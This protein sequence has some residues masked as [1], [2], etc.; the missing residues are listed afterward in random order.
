MRAHDLKLFIFK[1]ILFSICPAYLLGGNFSQFGVESG[2]PQSLIQTLVQDKDGNLWIG[3]M[4]GVSKYNGIEF[5]NYSKQDGL[6]EDRV[7]SCLLDKKGNIWFGHWGGGISK[8]D[9]ITKK[10]TAVQIQNLVV[11]KPITCI[12]ED[13]TGVLW[14]GTEGIGMLKMNPENVSA[15]AIIGQKEGLVSKNIYSIIEEKGGALWLGTDIGITK[16]FPSDN[17]SEKLFNN[18]LPP[19]EVRALLEDHAGNIWIGTRDS[20]LVVFTPK[21]DNKNAGTFHRFTLQLGHQITSLFEDAE[22]N[23]WCGSYNL[24]VAKISPDSQNLSESEFIQYNES[25]G[26]SSNRVFSVMQDREKNIWIGTFLGLNQLTKE[27]VQVF[28]KKEGLKNEQVWALASHDKNYLLLGTE[29]GL[30]K[31]TPGKGSKVFSFETLI[32]NKGKV[33]SIL[34]DKNENFWVAISGK[35]ICITYP[36]GKSK[37]LNIASG[38]ASDNITSLA[39]DKNGNVWMGTTKNG[40]IKV[41]EKNLKTETYGISEGFLSNT[42]QTVFCDSKGRIWF[43]TIGGFLSMFDG[44][45]Y[46][47]FAEKEGVANNFILCI[48][49]DRNNKI[50]CGT[51]D[52]GLY[53]FDEKSNLFKLEG[54]NSNKIIHTLSFDEK[55]NLWIGT[56]TGV[57]QFHF[58]EKQE[59]NNK[60]FTGIEVAPNSVLQDNEGN[61]WYGT[62]TGLVKYSP[63]KIRKNKSE[64]LTRISGFEVFFKEQNASDNVRLAYDE[65]YITFRFEGISLTDPAKVR[66]RFMLEGLDKNYSPEVSE[67]YVSYPNLESGK[68]VFS[69]I[70]C[71]NDGVWNSIP[72]KFSFV[73]AT[74]LWKTWGF[75]ILVGAMILGLSFLIFRIRVKQIE[76]REKEKTDY[77]KRIANMEL[78]AL[79]AQMNPHFIFNT[80]NSIQH[81]VMKNDAESAQKYLSKFAELIRAILNNSRM[82][83]IQLKDEL[84]SLSLYMELESLRFENKFDFEINIDSSVNPE[85]LE[86]PTMLI[87]PYVENA[88]VHG[89]MNKTGKG[90]ISIQLIQQDKLLK[91]I[92]EDNGV[93][94]KKAMEQKSLIKPKHQSLA[95]SITKERLE[96]LN[97]M[98]NPDETSHSI[99]ITDMEDINGN[100]LGTRVELIIPVA[101]QDSE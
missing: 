90:K 85:V 13:K 66:Y 83:S 23:I 57:S 81:F 79:R 26:L 82:S 54:K 38:L 27:D 19:H 12:Y 86:V 72:A 101:H 76:K 17:R 53:S 69:V 2:L 58:S 88:I 63:D 48:T 30:V 98:N 6:A 18:I 4:G 84:K 3:T 61:F 56:S 40:V 36:N 14:F 77:N 87:Q 51:Y 15:A 45:Q 10:V 29:S 5:V 55:N 75:R 67:N 16:F 96:I 68:Y 37:W 60:G 92:I 11:Q 94:R 22:K 80:M 42:I 47:S 1:V 95:M 93:G 24:G 21:A 31:F 50:W 59:S 74:P 70:A 97:M 49:E 32:E 62:L 71:N 91:C 43:G 9:G 52:G 46:K 100:A 39:K 35:G 99:A 44:S 78:T 8:F 41:D 33:N 25:L 65:N 73:I 7:T 20:G 34:I 89:L 64:P 28:G